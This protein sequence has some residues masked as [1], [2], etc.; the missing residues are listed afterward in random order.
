MSHMSCLIT[1]MWIDFHRTEM[2]SPE[3]RISY[4]CKLRSS[5]QFIFSLILSEYA[6]DIKKS[7]SLSMVLEFW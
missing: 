1:E 3:H 7:F 5:S 6:V 4:L 2:S